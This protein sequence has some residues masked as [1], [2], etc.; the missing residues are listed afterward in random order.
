[1]AQ[2]RSGSVEDLSITSCTVCL[3][4]V[5][6]QVIDSAG[7]LHMSKFVEPEDKVGEEERSV[8]E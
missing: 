2:E 5:L 3:C 4:S 7:L 8:S 1:M 6:R